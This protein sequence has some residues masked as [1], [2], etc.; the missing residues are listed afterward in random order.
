MGQLITEVKSI[1]WHQVIGS[2]VTTQSGFEE[3]PV[4]Y[5]A[6]PMTDVHEMMVAIIPNSG[7]V[8]YNLI[9]ISTNEIGW[10]E[11]L[12]SVKDVDYYIAESIGIARH[13]RQKIQEAPPLSAMIHRSSPDNRGTINSQQISKNS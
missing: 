4:L 7:V 12:Q 8:S 3:R 5:A 11:K 10:L 1:N 9:E 6:A 2:L 13:F